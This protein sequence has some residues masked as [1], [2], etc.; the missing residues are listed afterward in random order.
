MAGQLS[1]PT[2]VFNDYARRDQTRREH[3]AELHDILGLRSFRLGDWRDSLRAGADAAW[4][5]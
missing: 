3:A 2:G 5:H 4:G 1:I